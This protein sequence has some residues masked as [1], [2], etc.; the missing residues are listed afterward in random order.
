MRKVYLWRQIL[1]LG[2]YNMQYNR[3]PQF[4]QKDHALPTGYRHRNTWVYLRGMYCLTC[5]CQGFGHSYSILTTYLNQLA[6]TGSK[7]SF[8][9]RL[10]HWAST[11]FGKGTISQNI[12]EPEGPR[13]VCNN[14]I[15]MLRLGFFLSFIFFNHIQRVNKLFSSDQSSKM[16]RTLLPLFSVWSPSKDQEG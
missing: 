3:E 12:Q 7:V 14:S 10:S 9:D 15:Q 5:P 11:D 1:R 6:V 8:S 2:Q 4:L 16:K 13:E